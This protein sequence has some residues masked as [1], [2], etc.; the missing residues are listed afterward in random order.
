MFVDS[1][2]VNIPF[3]YYSNICKPSVK[4]LLAYNTTYV[5]AVMALGSTGGS[6]FSESWTFSTKKNP[7]DSINAAKDSANAAL[8]ARLDSFQLHCCHSGASRLSE[9]QNG[10]SSMD[11]ATVAA[12][13]AAAVAAAL[14]PNNAR[15]AAMEQ[16]MASCCPSF[17]QGTGINT[18]PVDSPRLDQNQP[19]PFNQTT[20][21]HY[22]LP[23]SYQ[24]ASIRIAN[25]EGKVM[26]VYQ[27]TE[28]GYGQ[29]TIS[30]N[31]LAAGDYM[32]SLVGS[33]GNVINT[34]RM[35]LI[36]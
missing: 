27:I 7:Q 21:I 35:T 36:K 12:T 10:G 18:P 14:A 6:L 15:L 30:G 16:A 5:V 9:G 1:A 4:P 25:L 22:Y 17:D 19:N 23:S 11:S 2:G 3:L 32:Y 28:K 31:T 13:V 34:K 26:N 8:T 24:S 33:S 29:V 20:V